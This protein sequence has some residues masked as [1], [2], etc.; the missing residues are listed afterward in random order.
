MIK[1]ALIDKNSNNLIYLCEKI[2]FF[3]QLQNVHIEV[4]C[5]ERVPD[6]DY[7]FN[8]MFLC[9]PDN[10]SSYGFLLR[11]KLLACFIVVD[12]EHQL[13]ADVRLKSDNLRVPRKYRNI[14]KDKQYVVF[15]DMHNED[16]INI[17]ETLL[18]QMV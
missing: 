8:L 3:A 16:V 5:Y 11:H 10:Q 7:H 4:E 17:I 18:K 6:K 13:Y 14:S 2:R 1:I 12:I 9:E 15:L